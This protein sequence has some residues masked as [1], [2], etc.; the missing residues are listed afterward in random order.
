MI[1]LFYFSSTEF[2]FLFFSVSQMAADVCENINVEFSVNI[3]ILLTDKYSISIL[4]L[5]K[6]LIAIMLTP[7]L[8]VYSTKETYTLNL[9]TTTCELA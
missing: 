8:K 5:A 3:N 1:S 7:F 4:H 6:C 2:H 9:K